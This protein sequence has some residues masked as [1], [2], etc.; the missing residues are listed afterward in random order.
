MNILSRCGLFRYACRH[1]W[2]RASPPA[3]EGTIGA[4]R[5]VGVACVVIGHRLG[6]TGA[7]EGRTV[8]LLLLRNGKPQENLV[9]FALKRQ[10]TT[11]LTALRVA[12]EPISKYGE[13]SISVI[14][15]EHSAHMPR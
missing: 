14:A 3:V 11:A 6:G 10:T 13:R 7:G 5:R 2:P 4:H 15:A 9:L 8:S 12:N 1:G